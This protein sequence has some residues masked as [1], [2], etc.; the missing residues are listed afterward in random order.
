MICLNSIRGNQMKSFF[1]VALTTVIMGSSSLAI[2]DNSAVYPNNYSVNEYHP[3]PNAHAY[4]RT[5]HLGPDFSV[6]FPSALNV[7]LAFNP[8]L[9]WAQVGVGV[10][11]DYLSWGAYG[12]LK[13]DPLALLPKVPV[14]LFEDTQ[15]GFL[16]AGTVPDQHGLAVGYSYQSFM[17]GLRLGRADH[18]FRWNIEAGESHLNV[19]ARNFNSFIQAEAGSNQNGL[20]VA[21]PHVAGWFPAVSTG[22]SILF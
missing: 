8:F 12:S 21:N 20:T 6:G 9:N 19:A 15:I 1:A 13:L 4:V 18:G 10:S 2:A 17:A 5:W 22:F 11:W 3:D 7:G 14:G 16:G